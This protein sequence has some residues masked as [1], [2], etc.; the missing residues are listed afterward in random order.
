VIPTGST[1]CDGEKQRSQKPGRG[2]PSNHDTTTAPPKPDKPLQPRIEHTGQPLLGSN[3][4]E[5]TPLQ[6]FEL[7]WDDYSISIL[8]EGTNKYAAMKESERERIYTGKLAWRR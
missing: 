6:L 5:I 2:Q 3:D 4:S 8:V 1:T 7:F